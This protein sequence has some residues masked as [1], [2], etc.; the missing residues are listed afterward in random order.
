MGRVQIELS[1]NTYALHGVQ[2]FTMALVVCIGALFATA[3]PVWGQS[4]T[5]QATVQVQDRF[6]L[7]WEKV[8]FVGNHCPGGPLCQ[9]K[10]QYV[11]RPLDTKNTG[12][13]YRLFGLRAGGQRGAAWPQ[14]H[15]D[16]PVI[17]Q[18]NQAALNLGFDPSALP[19]SEKTEVLRGLDKLHL[20]LRSLKAPPG[21]PE[22]FGARLHDEFVARLRVAGIQVVSKDALHLLAGQ[23][24]L[25]L[26]FSFTDPDGQCR[27]SYSVF[28][29]LSQEVL[30]TR[31]L[32]IKVVAG[33][34]SFSI[35]S[36]AKDHSGDEHQAI[37]RVADA[38]IRDHQHVNAH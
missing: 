10:R 6:W 1:L 14:D 5:G 36:S 37:L 33:V 34:W 12:F 30:L 25:N 31:D 16:A 29:S 2:A 9:E 24:T 11:S 4:G 38:F 27:Y 13:I 32:R 22:D 20:D 35:G 7:L 17:C 21:F 8:S 3:G 23:P 19:R 26:Y 28:A 18:R 15:P